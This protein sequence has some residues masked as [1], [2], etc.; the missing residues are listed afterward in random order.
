MPKGDGSR[1]RAAKAANAP[2][3][4]KAGAK[5]QPSRSTKTARKKDGS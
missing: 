5:K 1:R 3:E 4:S 2:G